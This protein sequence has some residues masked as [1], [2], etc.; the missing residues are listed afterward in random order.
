M[1][2][3]S[4][5]RC[6]LV[7]AMTRGVLLPTETL[8]SVHRTNEPEVHLVLCQA[9][10]HR[11]ADD[12]GQTTNAAAIGTG[13]PGSLGPYAVAAKDCSIPKPAA[14]RCFSTSRTSRYR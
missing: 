3:T 4:G 11:V 7:S 14:N 12:H 2:L 8:R 10:G 6:D 13:M 5:N 9:A 1:K